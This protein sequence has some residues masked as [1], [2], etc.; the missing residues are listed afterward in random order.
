MYKRQ[1]LQY[2]FTQLIDK[3]AENP[4]PLRIIGNLPYNISTPLIFHLLSYTEEK[5]VQDMHFMLQKEVVERMASGENSKAF[6][7]LSIMTQYQCQVIPVMEIGPEAFKPAPKVDSAIVRLIPHK[8]IKNPVKDINSL[9]KVCLAA[10]NQR[11]KTIRN[12][13]KKLISAEQLTELGIDP[14]LRP[15]NLALADFVMLANFVTDN[16]VDLENA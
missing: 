9:N 5:L 2:D 11:R 1:A 4:A 13:F 3:D 15:E 8:T 12:S 16:P 6:G 10:F 14:G 7:R